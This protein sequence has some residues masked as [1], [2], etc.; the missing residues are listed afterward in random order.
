MSY[1]RLMKEGGVLHLIPRLALVLALAAS[2]VVLMAPP[3]QAHI[4]PPGCNTNGLPVIIS[5]PPA[6]PAVYRDGDTIPYEV[7]VFVPLPSGGVNPCQQTDIT[8]RFTPPGGPEVTLPA[9]ALLNPG[10]SRTFT[11]A[12][13][14]ALNYVVVHAHE[15]GGAVTASARANGTGHVSANNDPSSGT[16]EITTPITHIGTRVT[17]TSSTSTVV[18]GGTVTLTVTEANTGDVPLTSPSVVLDP[19]LSVSPLIKTSLSFVDGDP[20]NAG[21]LDPGE[22]WRWVISG[23]VVSSTT[24]YQA[25]GHGLDPTGADVTFTTG[26][27][28]ERAEV[29]VDVFRV[30]ASSELGIGLMIGGLATAMV[31]FLLRRGR[32][33]Q[34][35]RR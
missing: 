4:E 19:P 32:R 30:P 5:R 8:T 15:V 28:A 18:P 11:S 31:L 29:T 2:L 22:T 12:D 1:L 14:A 33:Y 21:V 9:I 3:A 23:V 10:D 27:T 24:T 34:L 17:I 13:N 16:T 7:T 20:A 6:P 26:Y 35:H 25:T